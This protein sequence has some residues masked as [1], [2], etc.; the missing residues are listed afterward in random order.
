[1]DQLPSDVI[2]YFF[3]ILLFSSIPDL[4]NLRCISTN[5][6]TKVDIFPWKI[7][8]QNGGNLEGLYYHLI[9]YRQERMALQLVPY[10]TNIS[11]IDH[12]IQAAETGCFQ[13]LNHFWSQMVSSEMKELAA[14]MI[15]S[16]YHGKGSFTPKCLW[17]M[18]QKMNFNFQKTDTYTIIF[19]RIENV[20]VIVSTDC[21]IMIGVLDVLEKIIEEAI[22]CK[23]VQRV[24]EFQEC[25][26]RIDFTSSRKADTIQRLVNKAYL[27]DAGEIAELLAPS[28]Y[29]KNEKYF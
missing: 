15:D 8:V 27:N 25:W 11:L 3:T 22:D 2:N 14:M 29:K 1:M 21:L 17:R 23:D 16:I 26:N 12:C 5:W 28:D 13:I 9:G 20:R 6:R 19:Y 24:Q 7:Y 10:I 18:F 4:L